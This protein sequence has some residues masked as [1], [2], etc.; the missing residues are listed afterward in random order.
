MRGDFRLAQDLAGAAEQD[1]IAVVIDPRARAVDNYPA[2]KIERVRQLMG[3]RR[4]IQKSIRDVKREDAVGLELAQVG[5]D[6]F[7]GQQMHRD[8]V[9]TERIDGEYVEVLRV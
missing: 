2:A 3:Q 4:Q 9:A 8:G 1:P 7:A 5:L 6:R